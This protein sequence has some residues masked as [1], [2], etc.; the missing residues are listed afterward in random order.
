MIMNSER[1]SLAL[2]H[3]SREKLK[4]FTSYSPVIILFLQLT[5]LASLE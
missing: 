5:L 1:D 3:D 4:E 2:Y